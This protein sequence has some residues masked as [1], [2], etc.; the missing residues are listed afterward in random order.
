MDTLFWEDSW[1]GEELLKSLFTR[2]YHQLDWDKDG[3]VCD[4]GGCESGGG[5]GINLLDRYKVF[6][7]AFDSLVNRYH[8][9]V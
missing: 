1:V 3:R 7:N 6:F 8:L 9:K 4:L 2:L 5:R